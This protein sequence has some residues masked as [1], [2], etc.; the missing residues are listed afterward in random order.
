MSVSNAATLI[1]TIGYH[2]LEVKIKLYLQI[3]LNSFISSKATTFNKVNI[4]CPRRSFLSVVSNSVRISFEAELIKDRI[5]LTATSLTSSDCRWVS[6]ILAKVVLSCTLRF[7]RSYTHFYWDQCVLRAA[8]AVREGLKRSWTHWLLFCERAP[9]NNH[10]Q[11]KR[12]VHS[13]EIKSYSW[14]CTTGKQHLNQQDYTYFFWGFEVMINR[15]KSIYSCNCCKDS[16]SLSSMRV[17]SLAKFSTEGVFI[18][19]THTDLNL[20]KSAIRNLS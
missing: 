18:S 3:H 2:K 4:K 20:I 7:G 16:S 6:A 10:Q 13:W 11:I 12:S 15:G 17:F 8:V 5:D 14:V 1:R 19:S 9:V